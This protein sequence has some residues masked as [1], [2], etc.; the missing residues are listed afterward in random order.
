MTTAVQF[1]S[2]ASLCDEED[3]C[4]ELLAYTQGLEAAYRLSTPLGAQRLNTYRDW[5]KSIL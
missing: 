3:T 2:V 4:M 1:K 5:G